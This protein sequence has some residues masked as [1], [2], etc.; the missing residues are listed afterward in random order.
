MPSGTY[1][2]AQ[3]SPMPKGPKAKSDGAALGMD[4]LVRIE[5]RMGLMPEY[6]V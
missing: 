2:G 4:D 6:L 5:A 3:P 1:T